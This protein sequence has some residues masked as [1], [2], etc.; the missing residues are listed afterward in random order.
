[1][2]TGFLQVN[3]FQCLE[4]YLCNV[5]PDFTVISS[6]ENNL[7]NIVLILVG[8]DCTRKSP[9]TFFA[10]SPQTKLNKKINYNFA[11]IDLSKH[12][13]NKLPVKC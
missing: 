6:Q 3:V 5:S 2:R 1:M 11:W 7:Y 10:H 9:V 8:Q 13:T 4:D 12:Y